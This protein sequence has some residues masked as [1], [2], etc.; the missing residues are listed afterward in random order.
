MEAWRRQNTRLRS[1]ASKWQRKERKVKSL[2]R[3]RLFATPWTVACTRLL[4]PWDFLGKSTRVGWHFLLQGIF[5]T[6]W[7]NPGLPHCR[8]T[9]SRLSPQ[10]SRYKWQNQQSNPD[11]TAAQ[12]HWLFSTVSSNAEATSTR[13]IKLDGSMH[14]EHCSHKTMQV[15]C[16]E[17]GRLHCKGLYLS[18]IFLQGKALGS[19]CVGICSWRWW[20]RFQPPRPHNWWDS[21]SWYLVPGK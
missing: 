14:H 7:S 4:C 5:P 17:W 8:Q 3:V 12:S 20:E 9:L 2:S 1:Q 10:G 13:G 19:I 15:R 18:H 21:G 16:P 11:S 6:Q